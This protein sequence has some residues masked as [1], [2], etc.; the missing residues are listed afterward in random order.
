MCVLPLPALRVGAPWHESLAASSACLSL[1]HTAVV[2]P[3]C[4]PGP[5]TTCWLAAAHT[6]WCHRFQAQPLLNHLRIE[7]RTEL[8]S[9]R[10]M[11]TVRV[12]THKCCV[13]SENRTKRW[14]FYIF[15]STPHP[16]HP[17]QQKKG[18]RY[19]KSETWNGF[20]V[21]ALKLIALCMTTR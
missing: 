8:W 15:L 4:T 9:L 2:T 20:K 6:A 16:L 17:H 19:Y 11:F 14:V 7:I 10:W 13:A 12:I 5:H 18:K 3:C 1:L 21:C